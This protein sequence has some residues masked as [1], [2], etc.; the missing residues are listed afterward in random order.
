MTQLTYYTT[1]LRAIALLIAWA[2][3]VAALGAF[4]VGAYY[5]YP[6]MKK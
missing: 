1:V 2:G 5:L 3:G 4:A 6:W